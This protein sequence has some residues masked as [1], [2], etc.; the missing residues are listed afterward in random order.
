MVMENFYF[1][2][3]VWKAKELASRLGRLSLIVGQEQPPL[4]ARRMEG[5]EGENGRGGTR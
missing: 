2:P 4:Q 5:G 3:S 1:D